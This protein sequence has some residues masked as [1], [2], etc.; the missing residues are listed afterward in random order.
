M[1]LLP[2]TVRLSQRLWDEIDA[3]AHA[4]GVSSAEIMREAVIRF[5]ERASIEREK[6]RP[7]GR[8]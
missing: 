5:L 3:L 8:P 6:G 4:D 1:A 7:K 2:R